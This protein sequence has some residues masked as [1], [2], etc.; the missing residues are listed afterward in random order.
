VRAEVLLRLSP[1]VP[2]NALNYALGITDM[3]FLSYSVASLFGMIPG[4]ILYCYVGSTLKSVGDIAAGNMQRTPE[5]EA[6][7]WSLP[8]RVPHTAKRERLGPSSWRTHF[9]RITLRVALTPLCL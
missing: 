6:F 9:P 1:I 3:S 8:F 4:T 7:F 2:F 5:Q